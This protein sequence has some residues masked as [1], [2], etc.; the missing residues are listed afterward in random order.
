M[1]EVDELGDDFGGVLRYIGNNLLGGVYNC[2]CS[3][4]VVCVWLRIYIAL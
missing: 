2:S 1:S 4:V 3:V